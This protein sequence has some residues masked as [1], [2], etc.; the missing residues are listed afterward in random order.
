MEKRWKD[1]VSTAVRSKGGRWHFPNAVRKYGSE[2]F[3]H[4][5]LAQSRTLEDG[6]ATEE[7]LILQ[8]DTRNPERGFNLAKGGTHIPHLIRKN[9]WDNPE[10]RE[11]RLN[12]IAKLWK[13]PIYRNKNRSANR[14]ALN[15]PESKT[16]RITASKEVQSRPGVKE[17]NVKW[18]KGR[19][20]SLEHQAKLNTANTGKVRSPETIAKLC[21][22]NK[23]KDPEVRAKIAAKLIEFYARKALTGG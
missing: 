8:Y 23:S 5:V 12:Q 7:E 10:Y 22:S 11:K 17:K 21:A 6:N 13:D 20:R 3:T 18:H 19:V 4:E 9:P 16:K 1:H 15:T 14:I 2:A